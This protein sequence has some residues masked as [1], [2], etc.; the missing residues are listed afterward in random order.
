MTAV[1][2]SVVGATLLSLLSSELY[3]WLPALARRLVRYQANRLPPHISERFAEEWGADIDAI[4]GALSQCL[5]AMDLFRARRNIARADNQRRSWRRIVYDAFEG[6]L[7]EIVLVA[8]VPAKTTIS[9]GSAKGRD[10]VIAAISS[11][12]RVPVHYV[13]CSSL[14]ADDVWTI[15]SISLEVYRMPLT[16][17]A[18]DPPLHRPVVEVASNGRLDVVSFCRSRLEVVDSTREC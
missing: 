9:G 15:G 1:V 17:S 10:I 12:S 2:L 5:F 8:G 18:P 14:A 13:D 7:E 3:A 4:P 16:R 6:L 11:L